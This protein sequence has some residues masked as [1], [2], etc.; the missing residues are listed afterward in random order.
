M[1]AFERVKDV[2]PV[3]IARCAHPFRGI[4]GG[5]GYWDFDVPVL[6]ADYVTDDA[7]TGFVHTAPGHG[8]DDY[9]TFV[10]YRAAFEACGTREVPHTVAED[11]SYY[12]DIPLFAGERIFDD[13]GRDGGA[14]EAVIKT[15]AEV[16]ALVARGRLKHQY[17][18]SWR[19]K[20]PLLFRNTPQWFIAMDKPAPPRVSVLGR[21]ERDP[22]TP[23]RIRRLLVL[24]SSG[25][26][27]G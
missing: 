17:P 4:A 25:Q 2:L 22:R 1:S 27:R 6:Q 9:N 12:P 7:G 8:A 10:K 11:S 5:N 13:K 19:S 3:M 20:A 18:H 26:A 16:G 21:A 14:N 23:A 15:L 24:R